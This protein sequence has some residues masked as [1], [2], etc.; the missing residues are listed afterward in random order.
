MCLTNTIIPSSTFLVQITTERLEELK[1][2][3]PRAGPKYRLGMYF[4]TIHNLQEFDDVGQP[5]EDGY[6]SYW[7]T[8]TEVDEELGNF[9]FSNVTGDSASVLCIDEA[10]DLLAVREKQKQLQQQRLLEREAQMKYKQ[11]NC[12]NIENY[13]KTDENILERSHESKRSSS[14]RQSRRS[15]HSGSDGTYDTPPPVPPP[16][17]TSTAP[18]TT[19]TDDVQDHTYET[20]DDCKEEYQAHIEAIY[21]SKASEG[22]RG[23]SDSAAKPVN[24][25]D[26]GESDRSSSTGK[27]ARSASKS[28]HQMYSKVR[29]LSSPQSPDG[30]QIRHRRKLSEPVDPDMNQRKRRSQKIMPK[31]ISFP[32]PIKGY[33]L[34][35]EC[36]EYSTLVP[37]S[38]RMPHHWTPASPERHNTGM[39]SP[40]RRNEG[41]KSSMRQQQRAPSL[42]IKHKGKT[43]LIPVVDS[44]L[45]QRLEKVKGPPQVRT[46]STLP[47]HHATLN[48]S[49]LKSNNTAVCQPSNLVH[50]TRSHASPPKMDCEQA[51]SHKRKGSKNLQS[52]A[53]K[54]VTHYGVL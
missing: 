6:T 35:E 25:D 51:S 37:P 12:R 45:Q 14:L 52:S 16:R 32:P 23:S 2:N 5:S 49:A 54:Q 33:Q 34:S 28:P 4:D 31:Q 3:I 39:V 26:G 8:D 7:E 44:R 29:S 30:V 48:T 40:E 43:Y 13:S 21:F 36:A 27:G 53:P 47:R 19:H 15:H 42:F 17:R 24:E 46:F 50:S 18:T 11:E 1:E 9:I 22:S 10:M 20:L 38:E 41:R